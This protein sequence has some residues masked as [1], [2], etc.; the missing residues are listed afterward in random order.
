MNSFWSIIYSDEVLT[1]MPKLYILE[2]FELYGLVEGEDYI[3]DTDNKAF[4]L[5]D[6]GMA[7]AE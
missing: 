1:S 4:I 3:V 2:E 6:S 5:T 7:K